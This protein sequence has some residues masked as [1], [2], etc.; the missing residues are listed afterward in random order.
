MIE[1]EQLMDDSTMVF[2]TETQQKSFKVKF[3]GEIRNYTQM[4]SRE[5][6]K[7][8]GLMILWGDQLKVE[9]EKIE[10]I[11]QD[12]L[13]AK[14]KFK[15]IVVIILLVYF[16]VNDTP[17]NDE[18]K[19]K[20]EA[21]V[22][23]YQDEDCGVMLLGDFNA[24]VGFI[25]DQQLNRNGK[26][27]LDMMERFNLILLNGDER[28]DGKSTWQQGNKKSSIDHILVNEKMYNRFRGMKIDEDKEVLDFSDHNLISA[29]FHM[30]R[31]RSVITEGEE[32]QILRINDRT[33][34]QFR[35]N[36][37]RKLDEMQEMINLEDFNEMIKETAQVVM[38]RTVKTRKNQKQLEEPIWFN[39]NIKRE[40]GKR[41]V[42][43]KKAR[44]ATN[45]EEKTRLREK[46]KV[47]KAKVNELVG[48]AVEIYEVK[49]TDKI[50][51]DRNRSK[52]LWQHVNTLKK[53]DK[54]TKKE[55]KLYKEDGEKI[56]EQN[57]GAELK[58]KWIPVYQS[59]ENNIE[60]VWNNQEKER[61]TEETNRGTVY[62]R[63]TTGLGYSSEQQAIVPQMESLQFNEQLIEHMDM[64]FRI[65]HVYKMCDPEIT[66][67]EIKHQ[68]EKM[69]VG[70][71]AG[72][73]GVKIELYKCLCEDES[74]INNLKDLFNQVLVTGVIPEEWKTSKT[75]LIEKKSKPK[76]NELRP[77][78]LMNCYYK[79]F[80]GIIKEKIEKH[81]ENNNLVNNYQ[82]GSTKKRRIADNLFILRYC[83]EESFKNKKE[84]YI[85]SIDYSK[86][87]DSVKRS[88]LIETLK[89]CK[90]HENVIEIISK[91]YKGDKTELTLNGIKY[92]DIEITSGIRQG[93]NGSPL[94][95]ILVT[96]QIIERLKLLNIGFRQ[97]DL[98]IP[99]LFYVDD[100]L[101]FTHTKENA[102]KLVNE[103]E[104]ISSDYG[105]KLNKSKCKILIF[106]K[107]EEI[108]YINE[109]EV[110][111][112]IKYLG[113]MISN[114]R[115]CF[116]TQ[117]DISKEK[118]TKMNNILFSVLGNS[119]N[120][121]LIGK[122]FWKGLAIPSFLYAQEILCYNKAEIEKLQRE[123]YKA[124][125]SILQLPIYTAVEFL[126]G[127]VGASSMWA[128]DVKSKL[129]FVKH[130]LTEEGNE[131]LKCVMEK[132]LETNSSKFAKVV[133]A[134]MEQLNVNMNEVKSLSINQ[135]K[136][137]IK[138]VDT[139]MWKRKMTE[140]STLSIYRGKKKEIE[141]V[142][143]F[144][145]GSKYQLMMKARSNT[146]KLNWRKWGTEAEKICDLCK[147]SVETL[148]HFVIDCKDL[149][150][151]RN[152]CRVLQRPHIEQKED[153]VA[154]VLMMNSCTGEERGEYLQVIW[155]MWSRRNKLLKS[156]ENSEGSEEE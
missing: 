61:Y 129:L 1:I 87:F 132:N 141:E 142:E 32:K 104:N 49:I 36:I 135:I 26:I 110:T 84:L 147:E 43:N 67:G 152:K 134:Y 27:I 130:A 91:I 39:E 146:L 24:H 128:R 69:K 31:E 42:I 68:I 55:I 11:H 16:S 33:K 25:G 154:E 76:A 106:N 82:A 66:L 118:A 116:K 88:E 101:I 38:T 150:Q 12:I 40:I 99:A 7:G 112:Q 56:E 92:A 79:I 75:V 6:R 71:A 54:N 120:R 123:D 50:L 59:S 23:Q 89:K 9:M 17:R 126:R 34:E 18:I 105:L 151:T 2:L 85:I 73:D 143:W 46:Y 65:E 35:Q 114:K 77:I 93:C 100:G 95:F 111:N 47:Q 145:N 15:D 137:K 107:R 58:D 121:L 78:A 155:E 139:E 8:G 136:N 14:G 13:G 94:L 127:E 122:T 153:I 102:E 144:R 72:P 124:Y 5:D 103:I 108:E 4:R 115:D 119:C 57:I 80:M 29:K 113:V 63:F 140:K 138:E 125:R 90:V 133:S 97:G 98:K 20:I 28:C 19:A 117:K 22:E 30:N 51:K 96:Y 64:A 74:I 156:M 45:P 3:Q 37:R 109:I 48:E 70:K 149:Q 60:S 10:N 53:L 86:A 81:L 62:H 131:V 21:I 41:R 148:V 83:V 44:N 52:N